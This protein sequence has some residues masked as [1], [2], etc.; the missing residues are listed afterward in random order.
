MHSF[1]NCATGFD[2]CTFEGANGIFQVERLLERRHL[3][4]LCIIC[5]RVEIFEGGGVLHVVLGDLVG[6]DRDIV[7]AWACL[8]V[9]PVAVTML[10][11]TEFD[12]TCAGVE[13]T[14]SI[15]INEQSRVIVGIE[16]GTAQTRE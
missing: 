12:S 4:T 8:G 7:C 11:C 10:Y 13:I 2:R 15:T 14:M 1:A 3:L 9:C 5:F 6:D 16:G